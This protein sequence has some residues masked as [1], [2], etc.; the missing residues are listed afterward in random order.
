MRSAR[1]N[2]PRR[3]SEP[4]C[5]VPAAALPHQVDDGAQPGRVGDTGV[6][7]HV[8]HGFEKYQR[9]IEVRVT[10]ILRQVDVAQP[11]HR[12]HS[13]EDLNVD[14]VVRD[15]AQ[16]FLDLDGGVRGQNRCWIPRCLELLQPVSDLC[17]QGVSHRGIAHPR[18]L[19]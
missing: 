11:V 19:G 8:V 3:R 1:R 12:S 9:P 10:L 14:G 18:R 2:A 15:D 17:Q 7:V 16:Q 4:A 6:E 13:T 5:P